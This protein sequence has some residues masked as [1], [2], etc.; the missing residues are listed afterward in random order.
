MDWFNLPKDK[1]LEFHITPNL[2]QYSDK[3][4][5]HNIFLEHGSRREMI[6]ELKHSRVLL[7]LGH[8]SISLLLQLKR[9]SNYV[10]RNNL[11]YWF[12]E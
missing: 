8:K 4:K 9:Q 1:N 2:I 5:N 10:C 6:D 11:W 3:L 7:Y 12:I